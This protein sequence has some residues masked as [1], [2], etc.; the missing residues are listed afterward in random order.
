M[1]GLDESMDDINKQLSNQKSTACSP[2][3]PATGQIWRDQN[4]IFR[5]WTGKQWLTV[6]MRE[7]E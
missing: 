7:T 3:E 5:V 2:I 4:D 6:D 1:N